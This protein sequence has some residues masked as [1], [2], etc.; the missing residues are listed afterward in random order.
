MIAIALSVV[1]GAA[2]TAQSSQVE[3]QIVAHPDVEGSR[4]S[5]T[6]LA[7]IYEKDVEHWGDRRRIF[8]VDQ[9]GYTPVRLTFTRDVLNRTLGEVQ[10]FWSQRLATE[11]ILPPPTK[12]S[13]EDVLDFVASKKGAIGYVSAG[14]HIPPDVKLLVLID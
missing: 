11:R 13:D 10:Q 9:S 14:A 5:R 12:G 8:P 3:F 2:S 7:S 6:V 1:T 4:I